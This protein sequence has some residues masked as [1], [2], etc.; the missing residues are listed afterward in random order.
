MKPS[1][2]TISDNPKSVTI[3]SSALLYFPLPPRCNRTCCLYFAGKEAIVR[4]ITENK[5]VE[6][7]QGKNY[8][9]DKIEWTQE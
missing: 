1:N 4:I 5:D 9:I 6:F 8:L 2:D 3:R 7:I